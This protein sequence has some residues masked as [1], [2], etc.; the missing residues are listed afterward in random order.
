M[1]QLL[2]SIRSP[3]EAALAA[4]AA[5]IIDLKSPAEGALG[6]VSAYVAAAIGEAVGP[7]AIITAAAGELLDWPSSLSR[8][9]LAVRQIS[10]L[11][12]GPAGAGHH[13]DWTDRWRDAAAEIAAAG[14]RL[15]AVAY[16]DHQA[17]DAPSPAAVLELAIAARAPYL[18]LDTWDKQAGGLLDYQRPEEL[19]RLFAA[20]RQ[21]GVRT[22]A[23]GSLKADD[24]SRL[25]Q[26]VIDVVAI[27]GAACR[28]DRNRA[29]CPDAIARFRHALGA[30][31]SPLASAAA[32]VVH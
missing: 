26:G 29:L 1:T 21:S 13:A 7:P 17:A 20:A 28:G 31:A 18:L 16:A 14:K 23:A 8:E 2:I 11:K 4:D 5:D 9:L 30:W 32:R 25:P 3:E 19:K 27:R 22:V 24:L 12:L 6:A 15:A 10:I